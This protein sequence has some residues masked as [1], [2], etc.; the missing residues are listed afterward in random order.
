MLITPITPITPRAALPILPASP[1]AGAPCA[2]GALRGRIGMT[3]GADVPA[4]PDADQAREAAESE[5]ARPEYHAHETLWARLWRWIMEHLDP[6]GVVPGAPRWLSVLVVAVVVLALVAVL[7]LLLTRITRVRRVRAD[8]ALF[9]DDRSSSTLT[10]AADDAAGR[11]DWATAV[12][13]RFRAIIRSLDERGALEDY[14]G[15]TAHEAATIAAAVVADLADD[16][17]RAGALFDA[18]RYGEVVSTAEQ[19]AWMRELAQAVQGARLAPQ[20]APAPIPAPAIGG[21]E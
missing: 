7:L 5:L 9:D 21:P 10:R 3:P 1:R 17:H 20:S 19:D 15:M 4:T 12:V 16:L 13:E 8:R 2:L 14:P 6:S 11:G 18:V